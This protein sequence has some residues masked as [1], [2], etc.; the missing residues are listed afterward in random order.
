[1]E[2]KWIMCCA[3]L[4]LLFL[5]PRVANLIWWIFQPERWHFAFSGW[6]GLWWIWPVLG[7]IFLPWTT[8]MYVV[9]AQNGLAGFDVLILGL[10]LFFDIASY[11]GG[12]G[13]K[14]IP[15]YQGA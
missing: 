14:R 1:V 11:G 10:F 13:R 5:G 8:L 15:G 3:F 7:V 9:L 6:L 2:G 4:T 12:V